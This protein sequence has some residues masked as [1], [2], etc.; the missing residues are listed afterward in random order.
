MSTM[1]F[2]EYS[3]QTL[4]C[5][6]VISVKNVEIKDIEVKDEITSLDGKHPFKY[7][8]EGIKF[9]E[10]AN[11]KC[12]IADEPGLGKTIQSLGALKIH[13]EMLPAL[14]IAKSTLLMQWQYEVIRWLNHPPLIVNKSKD[15]IFDGFQVYIVSYDLLRR[16]DLSKFPKFKTIICDE[17]QHIKSH[18][19]TRTQKVR[20]LMRINQAALIGLSGTPI[21]NRPSEYFPILNLIRPDK[22]HNRERFIRSFVE[23]Y[24]DWNA[25]GV[26]KEGGLQDVKYFQDYTKGFIIRR[27]K[28]EVLPD[29][30]KVTRGL[31][32]I[33]FDDKF[34]EAYNKT[35][36]EFQQ[37]FEN[38]PNPFEFKNYSVTLGF[39][40]KMRQLTGL[41]KVDYV[42]DFVDEFLL[43]TERK[44]VIFLHHHLASDLLKTRFK[45][46]NRNYLEL[47]ASLSPEE[48][49][50]I[51]NQ[52][53]T[54]PNYR[55]MIASTLSAGEGLNLQFCSD[56]IM[57][58]RQWNPANEGQAEDRFCR[59]GQLNPITATYF[60]AV[61]TIDEMLTQLVEK[62]RAM[63]S[64]AIEGKEINW[65]ESS[66]IKEL[67]EIILR[68]GE[69]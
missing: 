29:L 65:E 31:Q 62:K 6:H 52:F 10:A 2:K 58:E 19:A 14:I 47:T 24:R 38:Q 53:K 1:S 43:S 9:I 51:I 48:K 36:A 12:L 4:S 54:D 55:V 39:L 64:Q 68:K 49:D 66:V 41:A 69:I 61:G 27:V 26:V 8:T 33:E 17:C 21:K 11:F 46:N 56:V 37:Y 34:K 32:Y 3:L 5:K 60:I 35:V 42:F 7:Q 22:F 30:P 67:T 45:Q 15:T 25:N 23:T 20:E 59:I 50:Q 28:S 57:M 44:I 16:L 40:A 13:P 63:F 18:V